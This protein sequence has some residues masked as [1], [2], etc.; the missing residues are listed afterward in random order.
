[1]PVGSTL[2]STVKQA[3]AISGGQILVAKASSSVAKAGGPKQVVTQG[4]AKAIVS[5][6]GG[7]I[8]A[9]PVQALTKAQVA[10]AGPQKSGSQGSV[11][12]TLQLPATNLANLANLPPGTKLY[13][14]TN[15]KNP[16]GKGKLLL[17]PQGAILRATNNANLQSGSAA[18]GGGGGSTGGTQSP[19]GPGGIAQHLTYTSYILKQTPQGTFLVG[20]PSPQTSGKQLTTGSVVQGTLGVN[21]SST[22][23]QQTL[24]VISGQKTT[25]FTQAAPGGQASLMKISDSTLKS[26]PAASQLSKPGTTMLRV[27]GGVITT[28][29]S[30]ANGPAQQVGSAW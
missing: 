28:A 27:T 5:G 25:L 12:A 13:L 1:M 23:G 8:V 15:S 17:I 16:S 19:A 2:P 6:G 22:Q 26:V 29:P 9:Q 24:K 30:Q 20:Q 14:T 7:T 11:M 21:T 3:V 10:A 4:V 18:G